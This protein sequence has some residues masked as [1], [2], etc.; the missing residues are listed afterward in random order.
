MAVAAR[1]RHAN[2]CVLWSSFHAETAKQSATPRWCL[3]FGLSTTKGSTLN[4]HR[5]STQINQTARGYGPEGIA[6]RL[7]RSMANFDGGQC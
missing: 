4:Q 1:K 5:G 2:N 3:T 6:A 7:V